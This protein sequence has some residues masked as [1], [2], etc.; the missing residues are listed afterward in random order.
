[1]IYS[2][3]RIFI[4][5]GCKYSGQVGLIW[6]SGGPVLLPEFLSILS[7]HFC[8]S[9]AARTRIILGRKEPDARSDPP[10]RS[11]RYLPRFRPGSV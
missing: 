10:A 7:T 9:I 2:N 5:F 8:G 11:K 4:R 6:P 3:G 1:M